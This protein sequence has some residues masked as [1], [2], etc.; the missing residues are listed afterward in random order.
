MSTIVEGVANQ[1]LI[2]SAILPQKLIDKLTQPDALQVLHQYRDSNDE[3]P[4]YL[5]QFPWLL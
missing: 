1:G 4:D 3:P 2:Y 5:A